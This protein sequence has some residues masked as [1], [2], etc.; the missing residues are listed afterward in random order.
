MRQSPLPSIVVIDRLQTQMRI[1]LYYRYYLF[2]CNVTTV[3]QHELATT[4][5]DDT[6]KWEK[7]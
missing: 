3:V 2:F 4:D 6:K 7:I 5:D 1:R